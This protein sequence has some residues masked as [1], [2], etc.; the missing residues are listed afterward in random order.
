M[1]Y[2]DVMVIHIWYLGQLNWFSRTSKPALIV[3]NTSR[4][5]FTAIQTQP[6]A[7]M[8]KSH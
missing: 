3:S 4:F 8:T 2:N 5:Q 1:R 7:L 6:I